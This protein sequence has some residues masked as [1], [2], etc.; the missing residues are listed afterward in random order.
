MKFV[1]GQ[2]GNLRGRPVGSKQR[3]PHREALCDLLDRIT[4]DFTENYATLTV[5]QKIR[6]LASF[7]QLYQDSTIN[8]LQQALIGISAN[9]I[10]FD[11]ETDVA[12]AV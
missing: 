2:S 6:I 12:H 4:A 3:L 7:T 10:T 8:D 1:P 9:T 5:A 11:F